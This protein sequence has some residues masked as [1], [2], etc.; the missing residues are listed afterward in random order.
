MSIICFNL[1]SFSIIWTRN[2]WHSGSSWE[3]MVW[4]ISCVSLYL[5]K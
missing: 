3:Q 5:P 1:F 4:E 2:S